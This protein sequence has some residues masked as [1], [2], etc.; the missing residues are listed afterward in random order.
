MK[1]SLIEM[2]MGDADLFAS[3]GLCLPRKCSDS[4]VTGAINSS[5]KILGTD[6]NVLW[7]NSDTENYKFSL[8]WVSYLTIFVIIAVIVLALISTV[9]GNG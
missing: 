4:I 1:Y 7:I 8:F 3:V 9:R 2:G 5:L 6:L